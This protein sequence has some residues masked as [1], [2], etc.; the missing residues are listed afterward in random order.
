MGQT[1]EELRRDIAR[2]R[3]DMG[4]TL[5]ALGDHVSPGRMIER[6]KNRMANSWHSISERVMGTASDVAQSVTDT[7]GAATDT[8]RNAPETVARQAQGS[9]IAA[10]A[11]AFGAGFLVAAIFPPTRSERQAASQL[12]D[13]AEPL[14]EELKA[15]GQQVVQDLEE[16]ARAAVESVKEAASTSADEVKTTA[17]EAV[18]EGVETAKGAS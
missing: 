16:P 1:P 8:V 2:T 10:G 18:R 5:E 11:V 3:E 4:G 7:T 13:K 9:P 17:Q 12:M 15:V 14:T 6:R